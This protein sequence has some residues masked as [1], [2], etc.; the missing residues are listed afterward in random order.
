MSREKEAKERQEWRKKGPMCANCIGF[1]SD[2]VKKLT[3]R[4]GEWNEETNLH[5]AIGEFKT[6]KSSWCKEYEWKGE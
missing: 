1:R 2:I 6:G 5:C 4:Y 3:Y